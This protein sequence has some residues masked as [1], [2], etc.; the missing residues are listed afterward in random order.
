MSEHKNHTFDRMVGER[1]REARKAQG[2]SQEK[3]ASRLGI[4]RVSLS[5]LETGRQECSLYRALQIAEVL[6]ISLF[7]LIPSSSDDSVRQR[8]KEWVRRMQ[9]ITRQ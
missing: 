4:L 8:Q 2:M 7:T 3:L 9:E 6:R 5:N 1:I